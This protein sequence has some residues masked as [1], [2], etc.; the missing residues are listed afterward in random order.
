MK[1]LYS[2]MSG[3]CVLAV[4][5]IVVT[6]SGG[7]TKHELENGTAYLGNADATTLAAPVVRNSEPIRGNPF[8]GVKGDLDVATQRWHQRLT[9]ARSENAKQRLAEQSRSRR[10]QTAQQDHTSR[11]RAQQQRRKR[12]RRSYSPFERTRHYG[13][14]RYE[15][16]N[17][18]R[19]GNY[20]RSNPRV[21]SRS[22][23]YRGY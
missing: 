8:G 7:Q 16:E 12:D 5:L 21:Q 9:E 13:A 1:N 23:N 14:H 22:R 11:K 17:R 4:I 20:R 18:N 6:Q 15:Y 2:I 19:N 3:V 10:R